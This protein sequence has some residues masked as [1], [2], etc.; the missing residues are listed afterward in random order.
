V[1]RRILF[2]LHNLHGGGAE[3]MLARLASSLCEEYRVTVLTLTEGGV[4]EALLAPGVRRVCLESPRT[5][6]ALPALAR[7]LRRERFDA[8]LAALTHVNVLAIGAAAVSGSL[9]RLHVSERNAFS[10]DRAVNPARSVRA[11]YALAPWLYRLIPNPVICVSQGVAQDLLRHPALRPEDLVTADNPVLDD[12]YLSRPPSAPR[13]AWL[14]HREGRVLVAVGRLAPQKGF[15]ILI[16][17]LARLPKDVRLVI[18]GEGPQRAALQQQASRLGVAG[19]LDLPGYCADPQAEIAAADCFVL[20]SRFE[21]SPNALVEALATGVPVV[22]TNCPY[23]PEEIL[24][25]GLVAPLVPVEDAKTLARTV[26]QVLASNPEAERSLR[27]Q[28]AARFTRSAAA[29]SY[30]RVLL[31]EGRT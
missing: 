22:A 25:R 26:A 3:K 21:G 28:A 31:P 29:R 27:Q 15:D 10:L 19:R 20:A 30:L 23:G 2:I 4:H 24:D 1:S 12:D 9:V 8:M 14:R 13:H 18:L 7:F 16:E 11:A 6:R 17:A 5:A